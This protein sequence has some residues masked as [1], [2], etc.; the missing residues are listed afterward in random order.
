MTST[1][2]NFYSLANRFLVGT[3]L[4][5]VFWP[6]GVLCALIT[7]V[8]QWRR[9]RYRQAV[10]A[11]LASLRPP[12]QKQIVTFQRRLNRQVWDDYLGAQ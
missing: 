5:L 7:L 10:R 9:H 6:L 3:V 11:R 1:L 4:G 12:Q 8:G 2:A